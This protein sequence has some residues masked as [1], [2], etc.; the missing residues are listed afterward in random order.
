MIEVQLYGLWAADEQK[1]SNNEDRKL[2]AEAARAAKD[3]APRAAYYTLQLGCLA[4][5][6]RRL[7]ARLQYDSFRS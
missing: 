1:V 6:K 5:L 7:E 4:S 3:T 2:F